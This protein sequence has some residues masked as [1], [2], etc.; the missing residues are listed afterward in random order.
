MCIHWASESELTWSFCWSPPLYISIYVIRRYGILVPA[1]PRTTGKCK[2]SSIIS[3][4]LIKQGKT[5][6]VGPLD[7]LQASLC[8]D[9]RFGL[10]LSLTS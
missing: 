9:S 6:R 10:P 8:C 3:G 2:A 5:E 4:Y 1:A 7:V